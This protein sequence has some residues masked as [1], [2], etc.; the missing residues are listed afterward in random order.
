[1]LR[2]STVRLRSDPQRRGV[3]SLQLRVRALELLQLSKE[4]IVRRVG[5]RRPVE[6][7]VFV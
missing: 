5:E 1:V 4:L 7:V 2:Q 6:N 3:G